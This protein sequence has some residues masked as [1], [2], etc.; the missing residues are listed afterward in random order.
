MNSSRY[1][2]KKHRINFRKNLRIGRR[3]K[4]KGVEVVVVENKNISS[5]EPGVIISKKIS[6]LAV[7]RN[8][9]R[10]RLKEVF[11]LD[12]RG[13]KNK[14]IIFLANEKILDLDFNRMRKE[15]LI[16]RKQ[17]TR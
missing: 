1:F 14:E 11:R 13:L 16:A 4:V 12:F 5:S 15:L 8:K 7:V 6:N 10:R 3:I 2:P 17:I 9:Y